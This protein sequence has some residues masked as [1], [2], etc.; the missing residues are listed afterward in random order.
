MPNFPVIGFVAG[1]PILTR[2]GPVPIEQLK[3]G[4]LISTSAGR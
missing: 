4:N 3:A 1:T 2:A